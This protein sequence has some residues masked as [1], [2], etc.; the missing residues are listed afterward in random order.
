MFQFDHIQ[1]HNHHWVESSP[2][3]Y[4]ALYNG[5]SLHELKTGSYLFHHLMILLY[6]LYLFGFLYNVYHL[7]IESLFHPLSKNPDYM[8]LGDLHISQILE[9]E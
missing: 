7:Q 3:A 6:H 2:K 8:H 4:H 9:E 5:L 1:H